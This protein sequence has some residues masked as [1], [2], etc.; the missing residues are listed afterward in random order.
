[1][2]LNMSSPSF[3]ICAS[4]L[5]FQM[6]L[7]TY[8]SNYGNFTNA[9]GYAD[10]LAVLGV[11][12]EVCFLCSYPF[13]STVNESYFDLFI[14]LKIVIMTRK[15]ELY[16]VI[17]KYR[18]KVSKTCKCVCVCVCVCLS[19]SVWERE[20]K[21]EWIW[22]CAHVRACKRY[23]FVHV[24]VCVRSNRCMRACVCR[25][26]CVSVSFSLCM[27]TYKYICVCAHVCTE[28]AFECVHIWLCVCL[29]GHLCLD[30]HVYFKGWNQIKLS[31]I[32]YCPF[33]LLFALV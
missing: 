15:W 20:W 2:S 32:S 4:V 26:V 10:G 27:C 24:C 18:M 23:V 16:P 13:S 9:L 28:W 7:V 1:M 17:W 12:Y 14:H 25:C 3:I 33:L 29:L 21:R 31:E 30:C 22:V 19:V 6:H 8:N 11:F 5:T